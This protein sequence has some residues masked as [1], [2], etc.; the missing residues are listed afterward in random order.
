MAARGSGTA[1]GNAGDRLHECRFCQG[2]CATLVRIS[3]RAG[4]NRPATAETITKDVQAAA[5]ALG[6]ELHVLN[7]STDRDLD[8]VFAKLKQLR[9]GGLVIS[10]GALFTSRSEYLAALTVRHAVPA[11]YDKREFV[12][13][14]GLMSYGGNIAGFVSSG[15]R[16]HRPHS[17]GRQAGRPAGP[18]GHESR[19][20]SST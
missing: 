19:V 17:Q 14:G 5:R 1:A 16:L 4:R 20:R 13:A 10:P 3:Q 12:V 15:W 9:G 8:E 2:L 6:L 7:A 18:A 11:V